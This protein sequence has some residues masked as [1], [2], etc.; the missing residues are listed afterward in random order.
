MKV[1][2]PTQQACPSF[3]VFLPSL[4][5]PLPREYR[6]FW[7]RVEEV[8]TLKEVRRDSFSECAR[9]ISCEFLKVK[10]PSLQGE[11]SNEKVKLSISSWDSLGMSANIWRSNLRDERRIDFLFLVWSIKDKNFTWWVRETITLDVQVFDCSAR[12]MKSGVYWKSL[13][14]QYVKV[15]TVTSLHFPVW[16]AV[17]HFCLP[18]IW[19]RKYRLSSLSMQSKMLREDVVKRRFSPS[20]RFS[21]PSVILG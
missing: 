4:Q 11:K 3:L 1:Q 14:M 17:P 6:R 8:V 13:V 12:S 20:S 2:L 10:P 21:K 9:F 5:L 16:L 7:Y 15:C 19:S 18:L